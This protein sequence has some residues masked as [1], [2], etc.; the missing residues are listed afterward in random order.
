M[1]TNKYPDE[2]DV[3]N[4]ELGAGCNNFGKIFYPECYLTDKER[5]QCPIGYIDYY[6]D[7]YALPWTDNRFHKIILCNPHGYGFDPIDEQAD[8]LM[9]EL[10]RVIV[11][12]G[13]IIVIGHSRNLYCNPDTIRLCAAEYELKFPNFKITAHTPIEGVNE[14]AQKFK[15]H[16]FY[17]TNSPFPTRPNHLTI[18]KVEKLCLQ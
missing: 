17:Q 11:S 5:F 4:I 16:K 18:I 13:E 1:T 6:C 12:N 2:P 3:L 9:Q 7:A 14:V 15:D 10:C 8:K